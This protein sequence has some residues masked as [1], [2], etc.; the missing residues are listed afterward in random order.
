M[1]IRPM[2]ARGGSLPPENP[3]TNN[4]AF[5]PPASPCNSLSRAAGSIGICAMSCR[6][7]TIMLPSE[8][9]LAEDSSGTSIL[10]TR[11]AILN[12]MSSVCVEPSSTPMSSI[13]IGSLSNCPNPG[14]SATTV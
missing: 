10:S 5:G 3:P 6:V 1:R 7:S 2:L 14:A 13:R 4:C 12:R 9:L 8:L 11:V